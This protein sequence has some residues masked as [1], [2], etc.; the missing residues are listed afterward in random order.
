MGQQFL[1]TISGWFYNP[2]SNQAA[3]TVLSLNKIELNVKELTKRGHNQGSS[4]KP[5]HELVRRYM[6]AL[7]SQDAD[8]GREERHCDRADVPHRH[9]QLRTNPV[10]VRNRNCLVAGAVTGVTVNAAEYERRSGDEYD[11]EDHEESYQGSG[12][13]AIN[14]KVRFL[15]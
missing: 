5:E 14:Y 1:I 15:Q 9:L 12:K 8:D 6:L 13:R 10:N 2:W 4:A 7:T 11:P 3:G